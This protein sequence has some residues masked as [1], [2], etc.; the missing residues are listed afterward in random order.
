VFMACATIHLAIAKKFLEKNTDINR[1]D[2]IAGTLYPDADLDN[3]STHYT[4]KNRGSDN[5]SHVRGKVNLYAFLLEHESLN[6]FEL[7]WFLHLVTDYLFFEEC[8]TES[9]L[10]SVT[11]EE[12]CKE[13]YHA[14]Y[15]VNLYLE[16][17]Y[18]LDRERYYK[19][20]PN[21]YY[22]GIPY[23]DCLLS[24]E[25]VDNFIDLVDKIDIDKYIE[26]IKEKKINVKP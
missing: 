24:K 23:E 20:Y 4:D 6:A 7:G 14:Y 11:Y 26:K 15:C 22:P 3:D 13:L 5:V 21:A 8:F 19:A 12:F 1:D 10:L 17:K 25:T 2:F 9:Y 16:E 18:K